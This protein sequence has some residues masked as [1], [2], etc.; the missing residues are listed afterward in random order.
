MNPYILCP[1]YETDSFILRLVSM[2]DAEDLLHC[3]A[4]KD[5]VARMNAD[6][7]TSSFYF[8]T[9]EEMKTAIAFWL[10]EYEQQRYVRFAVIAKETGKA[11]GTVEIFG[12][13][14][15]VL[16]IDL[17][18]AYETTVYFGEL[19]TCAVHHFYTD[20]DVQNM[21]IKVLPEFAIRTE[22]VK[23]FGFVLTNNFRPGAF[24]YARKRREPIAYCGLACCLCEHDA[25]CVGCQEGGCREH[26]WCK[27]YNCCK[28]RNL[29]GCWE[30]ADFPCDGTILDKPRIKAF[31]AFAKQYS[32]QTL[33]ECVLKNKQNGVQYHY[34]G[35]LTGDYDKCATEEEIFR[36][37]RINN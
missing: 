14:Y 11:I 3:Y 1:T 4:D 16:R 9:V 22:M 12:G 33:A 5:A 10:S 15:G 19:L 23:K 18:S 37:L 31:A 35:Q 2:H 29:N 34:K 6:A 36:M 30:C 13:E 7:C 8:T 25:T 28:E 26:G 32:V 20:F 27:N 21:C 24:Y 17:N